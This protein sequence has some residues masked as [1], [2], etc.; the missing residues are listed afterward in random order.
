MPVDSSERDTWKSIV[1][2]QVY[3]CV[4]FDY[5]ETTWEEGES[6]KEFCGETY[7]PRVKSSVADFIDAFNSATHGLKMTT[8][9]DD[10]KYK[11]VFHIDNIERKQGM[12]MWGRFFS[13]VYGNIEV[14]DLQT[15]AVVCK[16]EVDG[17]RGGD[18][19]VPEDRLA[20]CFRALAENLLDM[21][22]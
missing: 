3:A 13:R 17:H 14:I 18:D 11:F 8:E 21:K 9:Q 22:K 6:Y 2:E 10:A 16:I 5:S 12:T 7:E 19:F 4:E 20:K 1:A 15:E